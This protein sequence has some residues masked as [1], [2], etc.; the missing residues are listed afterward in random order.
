LTR[1]SP[2][3]NGLA[4]AAT[5]VVFDLDGV[6]VDSGAHHRASWLALLADLGVP[7]PPEFWR[8][9]IGRPAVEAV[10]HLLERALTTDEAHE[11][12]RRK[13]AHYVRLS[14]QALPAVPG[15]LDF[16]ATLVR[17]GVPRAVATSARRADVTALLGRLDLLHVFPVVIAA[18]DVRRGKPDPEVYRTAARGL[19]VD[20]ARCLVFEDA[21]VG[22]QAARGAGMRV[23][24][25]TTAHTEAELVAAG[26][27]R[28]I[29]HF[30]GCTWP[31]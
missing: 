8:R 29:P 30:E 11:L 6:L 12:A 7:A 3:R 2:D 16:V 19:G 14:G 21:L 1:R 13:H 26:A 17:H 27:E 10:G 4:G 22:V 20:A 28:A 23:I 18:E 9:T 5:A 15:V 25:V 24:G 31:L